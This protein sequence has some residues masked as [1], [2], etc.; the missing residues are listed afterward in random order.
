MEHNNDCKVV[1]TYITFI[2]CLA[3]VNSE[4]TM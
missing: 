1:V 2:D 4:V 3:G